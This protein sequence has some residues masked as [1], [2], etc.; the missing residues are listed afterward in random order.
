MLTKIYPIILTQ[1]MDL[2]IFSKLGLYSKLLGSL[3][4]CT[5]K[6]E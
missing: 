3:E 5:C 4:L 1:Q 2:Y 6:A